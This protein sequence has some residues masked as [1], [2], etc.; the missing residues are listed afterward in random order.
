[1]TAPKKVSQSIKTILE[2]PV[3]VGCLDKGACVDPLIEEV[4]SWWGYDL[5]SRKPNPAYDEAGMFVG[6]DLDLACFLYE[7][8]GRGAVINIPTYEGH[9]KKT[10]RKDQVVT[11]QYNRHGKLINVGAHKDFFSF[12]I[13]IIDQNVVGE[14]NVGD[15]RTFSLTDKTGAWYEGWKTIQFNPTLRENRFL[16]ENKLFTG[17]HIYFKNF[18]HPNRWTSVFGKHYVITKILL[19]RLEDEAKFLNSEIKR[20]KKAGIEFPKGEGPASL[21]YDYGK[22]RQETFLAFEMKVFI[23]DAKYAGE[24]A[25]IPDTQQGL[26]DAYNRRK[27][28]VYSVAPQLRFMARASE[29]AHFQNPDRFPAWIKNLKWEDGFKI[30]PRGRTLYQRLKLFQDQVGEHAISLLKRTYE[31]SATVGDD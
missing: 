21:E 29:Y 26:V 28:Y 25:T 16:S 17:S 2:N 4:K 12:N 14:D 6:T 13:K 20:L 1:M 18:I 30:P 31:K 8:A 15:F 7:L 22:S 24:Y 10:Q 11:S 3:V 5:H 9:S 27:S 19:D 23:P